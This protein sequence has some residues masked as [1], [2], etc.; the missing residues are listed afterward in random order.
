MEESDTWKLID[1]FLGNN[2]VTRL[3]LDSFNNFIKQ[4]NIIL[5]EQATFKASIGH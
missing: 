2:G 5:K 4:I 3:Q 1:K